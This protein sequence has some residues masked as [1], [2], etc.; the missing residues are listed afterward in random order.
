MCTMPVMAYRR[1][2]LIS[3][4]LLLLVSVGFLAGAGPSST[5]SSQPVESVYNVGGIRPSSTTVNAGD[6]LTITVYL[7]SA[8]EADTPVAVATS[9]PGMFV[10]FPASV[11]VPA[12]ID[13]V[14]FTVWVR[15][16]A[17]VGDFMLSASSGGKTVYCPIAVAMDAVPA[18]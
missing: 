2:K 11:T 13:N 5:S 6:P 7:D 1:A 16:D 15:S 10:T 8:A 3:S 9:N 17:K 14:S 4:V 12:G 18:K